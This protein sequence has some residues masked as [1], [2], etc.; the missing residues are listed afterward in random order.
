MVTA[1]RYQGCNKTDPCK[2]VVLKGK[3]HETIKIDY[4]L[5]VGRK[6]KN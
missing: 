5:S 6:L 2:M 1:F 4:I 3:N